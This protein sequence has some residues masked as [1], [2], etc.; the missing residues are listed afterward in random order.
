MIK[1]VYRNPK[2]TK[3]IY[4]IKNK[5]IIS[6]NFKIF[7]KKNK[8]HH[9]IQVLSSDFKLIKKN[10]KKFTHFNI[11][12]TV[13]KPGKKYFIIEIHKRGFFNGKKYKQAVLKK[14]NFILT[15]CLSVKNNVDYLDLRKNTFKNS[16]ANIKSINSLKKSIKRR[17]KYSLSHLSDNEKLSLGVGITELKI[18]KR[19]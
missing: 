13:H 18:L 14:K 2:K 11:Q 5:K 4:F 10:K 12:N 15:K 16:I 9:V 1:N 19:I 3:K 8:I 17:Y 7:L 6:Q